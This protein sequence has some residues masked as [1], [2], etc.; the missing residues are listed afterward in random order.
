MN[1]KTLAMTLA[2]SSALL[3]GNVLA[4]EIYKYTDEDGNV[5]YVDRPTTDPNREHMDITSRPTDNSAV[6][7]NSQARL[8]ASR[9]NSAA[10]AKEVDEEKLTRRDK[11]E[12]DA[13]RQQQCEADRAQLATIEGRSRL[14]RQDENGEPVYLSDDESDAARANLRTRI[15]ENCG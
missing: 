2:V 6:Q 13:A 3:V 8:E 1:S 12:A 10:R 5:A 15:Q 11:R 14:Y 7:A 4:G 9:E